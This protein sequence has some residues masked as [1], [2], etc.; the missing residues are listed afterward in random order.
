MLEE[1]PTP[2][3][4]KSEKSKSN[5]AFVAVNLEESNIPEEQFVRLMASYSN[6]GTPDNINDWFID[7]GCSE[8]MTYDRDLFPS[9]V[10]HE[11][12]NVKLGD[13]SQSM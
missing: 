11:Q 12:S 9:Y 6:Q 13:G 3:P 10:E 7:C 1:V 5:V 4:H 2:N 8:H